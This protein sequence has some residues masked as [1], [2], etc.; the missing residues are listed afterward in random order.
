MSK[1]TPL[2]QEHISLEAKMCPFAGY[3]MPTRYRAGIVKEHEWTRSHAGVFDVSHMGQALVTGEGAA[4]FLSRL[5]PSSFARTPVSR[6]KYTVLTNESGGII[7]DLIITRLSEDRFFLVLNAGRK[8]K[9]M[10]WIAQHL[11]EGVV[12]APMADR[13]LVALQGP[14][15]EAIMSEALQ[16]PLSDMPYMTL[17]DTQ[18][19]G[20][21]IYLSRLGYTGEDGFEVSIPAAHAAPF[22]QALCA[23]KDVLP[24]GLAARDSLRMEMGYPLYGH[25]L[26]EETTPVEANL[27]WVMGKEHDGYIGANILLAQRA[28]GPKKQRVGIRLTG[29]G[30]ARE[31]AEIFVGREKVGQ[32][33]SGGPSPSLNISIAQGYIASAHTAIGTKLE[34]EVRGRRI[35]A[36]VCPLAFLPAKTVSSKLNQSLQQAS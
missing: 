11:P 26:N 20:V 25:D 22:W 6:A 2:Y 17:K 35:G 30:I 13:A 29:S 10:Q 34:V 21:P 3:A 9:D 4:D 19:Q 16:L 28:N 24:V 1:K 18:W 32:L 15:A 36:E 31:G 14:C 27:T 8:D 12:C 5:T 23:H 7:D 33:T